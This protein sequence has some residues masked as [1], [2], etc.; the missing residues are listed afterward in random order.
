MLTVAPDVDGGPDVDG[1]MPTQKKKTWCCRVM[2][3]MAKQPPLRARRAE[4]YVPR[5]T[6]SVMRSR[7]MHH[8]S[9]LQLPTPRSMLMPLFRTF[10]DV[11][12]SCR[13]QLLFF[14]FFF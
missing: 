2:K 12:L 5:V 4:I 1:R 11:L 14:S 9:E 6:K 3:M 8:T 10:P 13:G 7:A